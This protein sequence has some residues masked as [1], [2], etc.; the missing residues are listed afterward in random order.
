MLVIKKKVK[1]KII[2]L[3]LVLLVCKPLILLLNSSNEQFPTSS[4]SSARTQTHSLDSSSK[5]KGEGQGY[6]FHKTLTLVY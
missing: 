6:K 2:K 5:I 3:L 4:D 1:T